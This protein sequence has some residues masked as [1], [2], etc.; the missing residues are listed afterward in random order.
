M[1]S[2][3]LTLLSP[4][5]SSGGL[6]SWPPVSQS[7]SL[8]QLSPPGVHSTADGI[9]LTEM[10]RPSRSWGVLTARSLV[11]GNGTVQPRLVV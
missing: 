7:S 2:S 6:A 5:V 3:E 8:S 11:P 1:V 10:T 4:L 9:R